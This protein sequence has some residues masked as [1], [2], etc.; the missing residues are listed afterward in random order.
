MSQKPL[1]ETFLK[2]PVFRCQKPRS[3]LI[4]LLKVSARLCLKNTNR[5]FDSAFLPLLA[6]PIERKSPQN[7]CLL[8]LDWLTTSK[9]GG[10]Q[11]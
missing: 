8:T 2:S 1:F 5:N 6:G 3:K 7:P 4:P 11:R 10:M 9:Q